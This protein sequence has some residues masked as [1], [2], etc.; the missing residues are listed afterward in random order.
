MFS[1]LGEDVA[2]SVFVDLFAGA[3]IVG[4]EALSRGA[5]RVHFVERD[6]AA[7]QALRA[8]L[9]SL[10]A[11]PARFRIHSGQVADVLVI[12]PCPF[13]DAGIVFA[14][15]PY[16]LDVAG[17]LTGRF[18]VTAFP[19]LRWLVVEHRHRS[20]V[21]APPGMRVDRERRFGET[22]LTYIAPSGD[23]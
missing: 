5:D 17:E 8:N 23:A 19:S 20:A 18:D 1:S 4:I 22:V 14:D 13:A 16:D 10:G 15:P 9:E 6:R 3:G 2:G 11:E 21:P 7:L 12:R